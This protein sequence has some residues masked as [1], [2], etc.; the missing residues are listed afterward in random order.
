M[1]FNLLDV[2]K[3]LVTRELVAKASSF[4]GES[5]TGV[6]KAFSGILP[7]LI[8]GITEKAS[9]STEGAGT[10]ANL[11]YSAHNSNFLNNIGDFFKSDNNT[12]SLLNKGAGILSG[13]FGDSKVGALTNL[14]SNFSGVKSSSAGSLLSMAAPMLL[15]LLGKHASSDNVNSTGLASLLTSQ[16]SSVMKALPDGLNLGNV[17][18]SLSNDIKY[19]PNRVASTATAETTEIKNEGGLKW[20]LPLLLLA[21]VAA[22][23]WYF[24]GKG[25][26][27]GPAISD[28]IDSLKSKTEQVAGDIK[29]GTLS[30]VGKLDSLTGDWMYDAGREVTIDLPNNAGK[31]VVGENSTENKLY[32]FLASND[33]LDTVKG[34]WFEFTNVRFKTGGTQLDSGSMVQLQNMVAI[35]KAFPK[36]EFKLGGYTDNTG[37]SAANVVLSQKRAEAVISQLKKLGISATSISGAKGYGPQWPLADNATPEG[38]AQNRRVAVNVKAK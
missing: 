22:A 34:N 14:I 8:N 1:S 31:L 11:A 19:V 2:A 24:F 38:R 16:K 21:L 20:L 12:G 37:D 15:S 25:C 10:I 27:S 32:K 7:S 3:G 23:A 17:F 18:S 33:Q 6:A 13:L 4:L 36:A 35:T 26:S 9:S 5:E 28:T 29:D 30:A